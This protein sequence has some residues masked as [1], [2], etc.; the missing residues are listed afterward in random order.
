MTSGAA[1]YLSGTYLRDYLLEPRS[2]RRAEQ[3][4]RNCSDA[5]A[6]IQTL[7]AESGPVSNGGDHDMFEALNR[8]LR[9]YWLTMGEPVLSWNLEE[10]RKEGYRFLRDEVFPRHAPTPWQSPIPCAR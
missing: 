9:D 5:K 2:G 7:L 8:E 3:S 10:R 4:R 1:V 6:K